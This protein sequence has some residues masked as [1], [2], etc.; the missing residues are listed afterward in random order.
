MLFFFISEVFL[1]KCPCVC[2][3]L[4]HLH[5]NSIEGYSIKTFPSPWVRTKSFGPS[6]PPPLGGL[7][8][9]GQIRALTPFDQKLCLKMWW[10]STPSLSFWLIIYLH[11]FNLHFCLHFLSRFVSSFLYIFWPSFCVSFSFFYS[12][13]LF[14]YDNFSRCC[15]GS[16]AAALYSPMDSLFLFNK[17]KNI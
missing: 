12:L 5:G 10:I 7:G 6:P 4:G 8:G 13:L 11:S 14:K 17:N 15:V 2:I 16:Y 3:F 9:R 1:W